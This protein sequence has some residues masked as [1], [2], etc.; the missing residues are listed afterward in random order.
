MYSFMGNAVFIKLILAHGHLFIGVTVYV[1]IEPQAFLMV[2]LALICS[3]ILSDSPNI[4]T[5]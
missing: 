2:N 1:D 5:C 3:L 4:F